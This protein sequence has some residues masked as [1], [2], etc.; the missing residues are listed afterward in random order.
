MKSIQPIA[1]RTEILRNGLSPNRLIEHPTERH[2]IDHSAVNAKPNDAPSILIHHDENPVG[3]E[4]H[5]LAPEQI[6]A[7]QTV[8]HMAEEPEPGWTS[9]I[10]FRPVMTGEDTAHDVLVDFN[11]KQRLGARFRERLRISN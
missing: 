6:D 2:A 4:R 11:A 7:P 9:R 3:S 8:L 1:I 5:R 10:G